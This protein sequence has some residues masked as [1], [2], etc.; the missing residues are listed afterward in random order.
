[1]PATLNLHKILSKVKDLDKEEQFNLLEKLVAL[2]RKNETT[3]SP[4]KLSK[5]SGIGSKVWKKTNID[6]YI[7]Q[8]RQW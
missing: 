4:A 6:D 8:E 3:S 7:D 1:M 2:I 5:I